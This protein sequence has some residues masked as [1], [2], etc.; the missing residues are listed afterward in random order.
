MDQV[1]TLQNGAPAGFK[2]TSPGVWEPD[3]TKALNT[4]CKTCHSNG[5]SRGAKVSCD[6]L[7]WKQHLAMGR[8]NREVWAAVSV[9]KAGSTCGW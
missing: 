5:K 4:V 6:N 3:A 9:A 8:T 2:E 1:E 7:T